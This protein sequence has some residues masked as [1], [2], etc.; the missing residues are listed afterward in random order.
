VKPKEMLDKAIDRVF[1]K[2]MDV[3][4]LI[5]GPFFIL[6]DKLKARKKAKG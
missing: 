1:F 2:L 4:A 3:V 5:V 6:S